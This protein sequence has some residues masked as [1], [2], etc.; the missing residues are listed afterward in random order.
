M[1]AVLQPHYKSVK[2]APAGG[3][4]GWRRCALR[5]GLQYASFNGAKKVVKLVYARA[6]TRQKFC[7]FLSASYTKCLH[8]VDYQGFR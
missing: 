4:S 7:T 2:A 6:R 1:S 5:W 3:I 8:C